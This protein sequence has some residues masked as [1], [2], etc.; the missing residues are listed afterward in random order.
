MKNV[1]ESGTGLVDFLIKVVSQRGA[2]KEE[3]RSCDKSRR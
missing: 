2:I 3:Y 1:I